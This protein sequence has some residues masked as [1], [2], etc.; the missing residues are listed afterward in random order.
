MD[1]VGNV[2]VWD[3]GELVVP[4]DDAEVVDTTGGGDAF[5]AGLTFALASGARPEEAA[6]PAVKSSGATVHTSGWAA[7]SQ[8]VVIGQ[9]RAINPAPARY[10]C[11]V[12]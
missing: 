6:Q 8:Q 2:F 3:G 12:R 1:G 4:L 10:R 5:V 11:L 9:Q 7:G